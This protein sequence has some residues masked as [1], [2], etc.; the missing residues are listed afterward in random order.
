MVPINPRVPTH[1]ETCVSPHG[2]SCLSHHQAAGGL[3]LPPGRKPTTPSQ[4]GYRGH[5]EDV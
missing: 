3:T 4:R 2:P 1:V 5:S